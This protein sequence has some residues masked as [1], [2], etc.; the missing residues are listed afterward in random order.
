LD[1]KENL[2][3]DLHIHSNA[4]DGTL[5]PIEILRLARQLNLGAIA[6]TDHDTLAGVKDALAHGI[7]PALK[8][9][10]GVEI[11]V[12]PPPS[13]S[14]LGSFHVLGYAIDPDN[15][16]LNHTLGELQQAR[17][18]RNPRILTILNELGVNITL[19]QVQK[20]AG[21]SQLGRPHIARLM[22]KKGY[23][24]TIN[25]A[26]DSYLS[27]GKPAYVDKYRLDCAKA[28]E[29]ILSAG[30]VPVLAHPFLI[31]TQNDK[32][33]EDLVVTLMEMGLKGLE[34]YYPEHS[35]EKT[36]HY[37]EIAK[38]HGLLA[39]GGSD[40]HGSLKPEIKM[41]SGKGN[42]SIPYAIYEK[43]VGL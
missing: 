17:K 15:T 37:T 7:P 13:F 32:I 34:V 43:L 2:K 27:Q 42:L 18:N 19:T 30:G 20:E 4:S 33:L 5:S 31:Q 38:R 26:F 28:I 10:T 35:P 11:S 39:T 9:L 25:E 41:G 29:I 36:A 1:Y 22:I 14:Y 6:I 21:E 3:I 40:F 12:L 24:K 8:F 16:L 23:V